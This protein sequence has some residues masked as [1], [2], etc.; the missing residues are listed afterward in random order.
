MKFHVNG[1]GEP[2]ECKARTKCPFGD[3]ER[4]HY[5][6]EKAARDAY[7]D[8]AR[9]ALG[10]LV[11]HSRGGDPDQLE[12]AYKFNSD[13]EDPDQLALFGEDGIIEAPEVKAPQGYSDQTHYGQM[14][15]AFAVTD[16]SRL[17]L[18][19]AKLSPEEA[20]VFLAYDTVDAEMEKFL[21]DGRDQLTDPAHLK[22][23]EAYGATEN[24][25]AHYWM[26][27]AQDATLAET[28]HDLKEVGVAWRSFTPYSTDHQWEID[29]DD[30][31]LFDQGEQPKVVIL[32]SEY[33]RMPARIKNRHEVIF[34]LINDKPKKEETQ[35]AKEKA[36][37]DWKRKTPA[38][39]S[40]GPS[41]GHTMGN[42]HG[43]PAAPVSSPSHGFGGGFSGG[44]GHG[45][46]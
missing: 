1:K 5:P 27:R 11:S 39:T 18:A 32:R 4:D 8:H 26:K 37:Q 43:R 10:G 36:V 15:K 22:A 20:A 3:L 28:L 44:F 21:G 25:Y 31:E 23:L 16:N 42:H 12:L 41:H 7:E 38:A 9:A 40:G 46:Y 33:G 24:R 30:I 45:R 14:Q 17:E 29:G 19:F 35:A 2:G 6:T 34:A 13:G